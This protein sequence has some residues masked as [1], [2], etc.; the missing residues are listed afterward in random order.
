V[1]DLVLVELLEHEG[2]SGGVLGEELGVGVTTVF[3]LFE[4]FGEEG[5]ESV[6]V[7]FLNYM[8]DVVST[9]R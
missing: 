6:E 3:G 5:D 1:L 9:F 4:G 8:G 2:Q 7:L